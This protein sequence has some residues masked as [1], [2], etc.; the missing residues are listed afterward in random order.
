MNDYHHV[1]RHRPTFDFGGKVQCA[2]VTLL[3]PKPAVLKVEPVRPVATTYP[4]FSKLKQSSSKT[5]H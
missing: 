1:I 4:S 3:E 5:F 2:L